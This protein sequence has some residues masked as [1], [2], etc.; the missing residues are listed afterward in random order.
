MFAAFAKTQVADNIL[1]SL[2]QL[3]ASEL[4]DPRAARTYYDRIPLEYPASGLRDDARWN[5]VLLS[6]QLG[7][8][9]GARAR[10]EGILK[11]RG[12]FLFGGPQSIWLDDAQ[13]ELGRVLRDH[14]GDLAGAIAAFRKLPK[15]YPTSILRD[16]ALHELEI[17][18]LAAGDVPGA[19][20]ALADLVKLEPGSKFIADAT[21]RGSA[22]RR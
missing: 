19:C 13:L 10:L 5:A 18:L 15:D 7:D 4:S 12:G 11:G 14:F 20:R 1:W 2:A 16:D 22:C 6:E 21:A 8:W 3:D 9:A 17:T